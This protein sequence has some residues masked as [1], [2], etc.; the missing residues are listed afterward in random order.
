MYEFVS[1][2]DTVEP[3][4]RVAGLTAERVVGDRSRGGSIRIRVYR[5]D[6]RSCEEGASEKRAV[7]PD[8]GGIQL[9]LRTVDALHEYG[10]FAVDVAEDQPRPGQLRDVPQVAGADVD[11]DSRGQPKYGLIPF[12]NN[13]DASVER[14]FV[15]S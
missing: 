1:S 12:K 13:S 3:R 7:R 4:E 2:G 9:R 6:L 10:K 14:Q 11:V 8:V 5:V 15:T